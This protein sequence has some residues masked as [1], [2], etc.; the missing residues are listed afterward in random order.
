MRNAPHRTTILGMENTTQHP[1]TAEFE[2]AARG[3]GLS[4]STLGRLVG[5][6]G[7]F[8]KRLTAGRRVWPE[9]IEQVRQEIA[10]LREWRG[11]ASRED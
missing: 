8:H 10:A 2:D 1:F 9:T 6:G 5:Q 4:P 11:H 7:D 3:L